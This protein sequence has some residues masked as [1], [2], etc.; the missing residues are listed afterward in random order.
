MKYT[1]ECF[2]V[3]SWVQAHLLRVWECVWLRVRACLR[4]QFRAAQ[5]M[6]GSL[7]LQIKQGKITQVHR[8]EDLPSPTFSV[9]PFSIT[10]SI[11]PFLL[12]L[13]FTFHLLLGQW[14][15]LGKKWWEKC[16]KRVNNSLTSFISSAVACL[17]NYF[18][19][20]GKCLIQCSTHMEMGHLY[21]KPIFKVIFFGNLDYTINKILTLHRSIVLSRPNGYDF[22]GFLKIFKLFIMFPVFPRPPTCTSGTSSELFGEPAPGPQGSGL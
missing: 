9:F 18:G 4:Q 14:N 12:R 20:V 1:Y 21:K 10:S 5:S 19:I 15:N 6:L 17:S 3:C 2:D 8:G 11:S 22:V 13:C 16:Q 7:S